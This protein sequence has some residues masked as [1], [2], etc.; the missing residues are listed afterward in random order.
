MTFLRNGKN[1]N[2]YIPPPQP[3]EL[4]ETKIGTVDAFGRGRFS[5]PYSIFDSKQLSD[6]QSLYWSDFQKSGAGTSSTYS[7]FRAS[8][9]LA[10]SNLTAGTRVRRTK[11]RMNY[12]P[13]KSQLINMTFVGGNNVSGITKK[14]GYFDA[15]NGIYFSMENGVNYVCIRSSVSGVPVENKVS[16]NYWNLDRLDGTGPSGINLDLTQSQILVIDFEWLGVGGVR[17]GFNINLV[18]YYFHRFLNANKLDSVYMSNPN[19]TIRYELSNDGTGPASDLECIC[20][21]VIS[22]GGLE[23]IGYNR[24]IDRGTSAF[25]TTNSDDLFSLISMR[26]KSDYLEATVHVR[27]IEVLCTSTSLYRWALL[28]NPTFNTGTPAFTNITNSALEVNTALTNTTTLTGGTI[29]ASGYNNQTTNS[30]NPSLLFTFSPNDL[31]L[32]SYDTAT[33]DDTRDIITLAVQRL[34]GGAETFYGVINVNEI[35]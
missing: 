1:S 22:E 15:A 14:I 31:R 13:G 33:E 27:G 28:L 32:G 26:L 29:L 16:Q 10:V 25:T 6:N 4:F 24:S 3:E 21:N 17:L 2:G 12:Q 19:Q 5:E 30:T 35:Y 20:S 7:S 23:N 8:T 18:T 9:T 34:S 11:T